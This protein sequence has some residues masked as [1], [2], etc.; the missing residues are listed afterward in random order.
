MP[1]HDVISCRLYAKSQFMMLKGRDDSD[2]AAYAAYFRGKR[3]RDAHSRFFTRRY[4]K[5]FCHFLRLCKV[6]RAAMRDD[7]EQPRSAGSRDARHCG[8]D[9]DFIAFYYHFFL[10]SLTVSAMTSTMRRRHTSRRQHL[11]PHFSARSLGRCL[12]SSPRNDEALP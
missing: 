8:H 2:D 1:T 5:G 12:Y 6:A 9:I 3:S 7:I 4:A 11:T 10:L